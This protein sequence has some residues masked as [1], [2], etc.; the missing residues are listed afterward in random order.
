MMNSG[1]AKGKG[2]GGT[3]SVNMGSTMMG[4]QVSKSP[5]FMNTAGSGALQS[6]FN[7]TEISSSS[8]FKETIARGMVTGPGLLGNTSK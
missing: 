8:P 6:K 4:T 7:R 3:S 2:M 5:S 1:N